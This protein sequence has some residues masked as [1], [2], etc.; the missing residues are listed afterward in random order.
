MRNL[1]AIARKELRNYFDHPTAYI[2]AVVFLV[3]NNFFF[4]RSAFL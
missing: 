1:W 3:L 4:F 2:L